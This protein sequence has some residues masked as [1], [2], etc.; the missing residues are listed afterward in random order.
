MDKYPKSVR[1]FYTMADPANPVRAPLLQLVQLSMWLFRF[2]VVFSLFCV[3]LFSLS[4]LCMCATDPRCIVVH[5]QKLSNS[6]D[7]FIRGEEIVS[8]AQRVH[9][10]D[11]LVEQASA[12]GIPIPSIQVLCVCRACSGGYHRDVAVVVAHWGHRCG[13][14]RTWTPSVTGRCLT[15]AAASAWS[16]W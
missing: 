7:M 8:G 5:V 4:S 9:D 13:C 16:V 6:Y 11:M 14:R 3:C 2:M 1:P 15:A 10:V 12:L